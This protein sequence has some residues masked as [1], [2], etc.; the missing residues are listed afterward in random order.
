MV[1]P[2]EAGGLQL[3]HARPI[4]TRLAPIMAATPTR[5]ATA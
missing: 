5:R 1:S 4:I 3:A 2:D